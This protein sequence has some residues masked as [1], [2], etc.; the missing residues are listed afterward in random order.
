MKK[1]DMTQVAIQ[2]RNSKGMF[3]GSLRPFN[4]VKKG[5]NM[6]L[7]KYVVFVNP[8]YYRKLKTYIRIN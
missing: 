7:L 6:G 1:K 2:S 4:N 8:H 3:L 5:H